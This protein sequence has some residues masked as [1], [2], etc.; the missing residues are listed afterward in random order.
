MG[1]GV[2][3]FLSTGAGFGI[4]Y[5]DFRSSAPILEYDIYHNFFFRETTA[6]IS[7]YDGELLLFTHGMQVHGPSELRII[8]TI[9]FLNGGENWSYYFSEYYNA[10]WGFPKLQSAIIPCRLR[11]EKVPPGMYFYTLAQ[12]GR[13]VQSGRVV[14]TQ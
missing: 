13:I 3:C 5:W 4:A 12:D 2:P 14:K 11:L 7:S 10:P 6:A 1:D 8:D 9:S